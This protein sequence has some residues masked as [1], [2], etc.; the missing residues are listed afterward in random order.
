MPDPELVTARMYAPPPPPPEGGDP[1][2]DEELGWPSAS[3][4][5]LRRTVS[6][7][8]FRP[9]QPGSHSR[10]GSS[11][12][13]TSSDLEP[14]KQAARTDSPNP[15]PRFQTPP[16]RMSPQI[17]ENVLPSSPAKSTTTLPVS[18]PEAEKNVLMAQL[19]TYI[20]HLLPLLQQEGPERVAGAIAEMFP[21]PSTPG[22][23]GGSVLSRTQDEDAASDARLD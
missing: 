23:A 9:S 3:A 4:S 19:L 14:F 8:A 15:F 13:S 16:S 11:T 1:W 21:H 18:Q 10:S 7:S 6:M 20:P 2:T 5:A 17:S 22:E 12:G